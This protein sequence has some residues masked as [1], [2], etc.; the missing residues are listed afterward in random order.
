MIAEFAPEDRKVA[1]FKQ[2]MSFK[3]GENRFTFRAKTGSQFGISNFKV[4]RLGLKDS[5][6]TNGQFTAKNHHNIIPGWTGHSSLFASKDFNQNWEDATV[7][8]IASKQGESLTQTFHFNKDFRFRTNRYHLS[9]EMAPTEGA[10]LN[11][12]LA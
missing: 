3:P 7:A 2:K 9:L 5:I 8:R 4:V 12:P 11:V 1:T 10:A 6:S